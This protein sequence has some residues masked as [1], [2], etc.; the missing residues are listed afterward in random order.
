MFEGIGLRAGRENGDT[1]RMSSQHGPSISTEQM[2]ALPPEFRS[3]LQLVID[4]HER[5]IAELDAEL[6]A[7]KKTP[8]NSLQPPST[9][10]P[11]TKS[12]PPKVKSKRRG[13][14][15]PGH[16]KCERPLIP[17]EQCD[18]LVERQPGGCRSC[19]RRLS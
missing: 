18:R 10:H 16:T 2:A 5:R 3:L 9:Q 17:V 1:W 6:K 14:R 7:L 19:G 4:H 11:H 13:G 15:Q 12:A 8:Q